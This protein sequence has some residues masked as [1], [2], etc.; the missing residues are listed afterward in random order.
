MASNNTS[1]VYAEKDAA[2]PISADSKN[3]FKETKQSDAE[4]SYPDESNPGELKR[5]LKSRHL[6]MI[7]I[8]T[9]HSLLV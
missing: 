2:T 7:A 3:V 4:Q 5:K 9:P 8:G 1:A 6:Q